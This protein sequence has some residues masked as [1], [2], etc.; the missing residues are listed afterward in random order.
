MDE[1]CVRFK[2]P[3]PK[4]R[5]HA[6]VVAR[7]L[8][9]DGPADLTVQDV[10]LLEH[11]QVPAP[12]LYVAVSRVEVP[13]FPIRSLVPVASYLAYLQGQAGIVKTIMQVC[14]SH[15]GHAWVLGSG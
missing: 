14:D 8:R 2:D 7:D 10:P 3:Y 12:A 13:P 9:L 15:T 1:L 4:A 6:L 11:M 5:H